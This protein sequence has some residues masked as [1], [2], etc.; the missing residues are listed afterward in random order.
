[1]FEMYIEII[2]AAVWTIT[3]IFL[4]S[5]FDE[6]L[7]DA[8]YL[9]WKI[10]YRFVLVRGK[11]RLHLSTLLSK[12]EQTVAIMVPAWQE[13]NVIAAML[14][15][16]IETI[17]YQDYVIFVGVYPNDTGTRHAL[18]PALTKYAEHVRMALVP[19]PG[20]TTKSDCLN[21]IL[22][23]IRKWEQET[24]KETQIYVLHDAED[25]VPRYGLKVFNY[26]MPRKA[27]VQLPVFPLH[28]PWYS[29]TEG[30]Y[31]D[32][33]AQVHVKDLRVREWLTGGVPSAGVGTGFSRDAINLAWQEEIQGAF[34][35]DL[36]TEDY[37]I[38]MQLLR[39][40]AH[41]AF[42]DG[43]VR[44]GDEPPPA[45]RLRRMP[46]VPAVRGAFPDTFW[47]SVRQKTRWTLGITL[48]GW[49]D[50]GWHGSLWQKYLFFRDRK[51]IFTNIANVGAYFI[52]IAWLVPWLVDQF[53]FEGT[54]LP[55]LFE[56]GSILNQLTAINVAMLA[57]FMVVR[58]L[59]TYQAFGL[60]HALMSFPRLVWA[61]F[62]NFVAT[63]RALRQFFDARRKGT[64]R[65]PWEK[66][67]H[68]SDPFKTS[69]TRDE[70]ENLH[71]NTHGFTAHAGNTGLSA[72]NR[73]HSD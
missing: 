46:G 24:G 27:I 36:L 65:I 1:M 2:H 73:H 54:L 58:A 70:H 52:A 67:A 29:F 14:Q 47:A 6:L 33:F 28:V 20:P 8:A 3:I 69:Q 71:S 35:E 5:G 9:A 56:R 26:L 39:R 25:H 17:H 18:A 23:E 40:G 59:C 16:A 68:S 48:Q 72:A 66:T 43:I 10:Y 4:V 22:R 11:P 62:I 38:S 12:P 53:I 57:I 61:N 30:H 51:S 31:L 42:F 37:E 49:E 41:S 32:E 45:L 21:T 13:E 64:K 7:F 50:L 44:G 63:V 34:R 19:H 55:P 60:A 15:N